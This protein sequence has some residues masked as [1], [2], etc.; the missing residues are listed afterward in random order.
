MFASIAKLGISAVLLASLT[1]PAMAPA[2]VVFPKKTLVPELR[3]V[4]EWINTD[5]PLT[6]EGLKGK[7]VVVN[8][9][10]FG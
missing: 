6:L 3:D 8:F 9:W 5:K 4:D 7:V 1:W 2:Q 10:T